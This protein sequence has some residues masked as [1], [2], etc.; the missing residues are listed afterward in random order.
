MWLKRAEQVPSMK[1]WPQVG[2]Q[3]E[4]LALVSSQATAVATRV[5]WGGSPAWLWAR[6]TAQPDSSTGGRGGSEFWLF[7]PSMYKVSFFYPFLS[8]GGGPTSVAVQ[9]WDF[10][11]HGPHYLSLDT[12]VH[13]VDSGS[14][15][16]CKRCPK[17]HSALDLHNLYWY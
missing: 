6:P 15:L 14:I 3:V 17:V 9:T 1:F 2:L 7:I 13:M 8:R 11:P 12:V 10:G 4:R 5:W 16:G